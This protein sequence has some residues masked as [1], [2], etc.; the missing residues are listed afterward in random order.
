MANKLEDYECEAISL[1]QAGNPKAFKVMIDYFDKMY[2]FERDKCV[3]TSKDN[4]EIHQ[5]RARAFRDAVNMH[6]DATKRL[7]DG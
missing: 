7:N 1:L 4:V 6:E 3:D 5:G 2:N